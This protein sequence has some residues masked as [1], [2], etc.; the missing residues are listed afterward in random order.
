M[1]SASVGLY[2]TWITCHPNADLTGSSSWPAVRPGFVTA[3]MKASSTLPDIE[4]SK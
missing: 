3:A 2:M 4:A 1:R